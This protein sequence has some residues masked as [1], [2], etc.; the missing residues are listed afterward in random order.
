MN[1]MIQRLRAK[2]N[3]VKKQVVCAGPR[4]PHTSILSGFFCHLL[5]AYPR[6]STPPATVSKAHGFLLSIQCSSLQM[7]IADAEQHGELAL[8]DA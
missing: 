1:W 4:A 6:N 3:S 2:I 5:D 8:K 7:A